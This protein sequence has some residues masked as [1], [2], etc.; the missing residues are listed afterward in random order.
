MP[1]RTMSIQQA[2]ERL[3]LTVRDVEQLVKRAEIP[4]LRRGD[5]ILFVRRD[6]D[7]WT[8][9][10]LLGMTPGGVADVHRSSTNRRSRHTPGE[11]LV[12]RL[13]RTAWI[14][15]RLD[16]KTK[17]S[18]LRQMVALA[19][20]TELLFDDAALLQGIEERERMC[21]T[22]IIPGAA[23]LHTRYHDPL[24][25]GDSFIVLGRTTRPI[26]AGAEDGQT[27]SIF[28]LLCCQ[29]D[30]LHLHA[31][32][33]LCAMAHDTVLIDDLMRAG[34]G[35]EMLDALARSEEAVLA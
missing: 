17:P 15:P 9:Q 22:A 33:R 34:S 28:F 29:D 3:H 5:E 25:C 1:F 27:T 7:A 23:L 8:S 30:T 32:A 21:S 12:P 35:Q 16:A 14:E 24:I 4:C 18:V 31:L 10:R 26:F 19:A 2:A 13:F 6:L 11:R 20:S